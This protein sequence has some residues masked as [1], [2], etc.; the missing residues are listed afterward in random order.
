MKG[1]FRMKKTELRKA[2][3]EYQQIA[4]QIAQLEKQ[5]AAVADRIKAHMDAAGVDEMQVDD[6]T[7]ARY[8]EVT[9][10]RFDS[11]AFA[12]AHKRLYAMFCKPQTIRRFTIA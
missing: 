8:K 12:A 7:T 6:A 1:S 10:N 3:N 4:A 2:M 11:K 9:S 5:K